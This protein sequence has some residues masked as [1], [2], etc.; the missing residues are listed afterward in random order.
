[1]LMAI[2]VALRS[3][4]ALP[5]L[6]GA[7]GSAVSS[8]S[9]SLLGSSAVGLEA[10]QGALREPPSPSLPAEAPPLRPGVAT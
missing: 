6:L 2:L 1:M 10:E 4:K 8:G 3:R 5:L 7:S 9:A